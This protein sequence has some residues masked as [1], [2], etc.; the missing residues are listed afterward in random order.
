M[1]RL[2]LVRTSRDAEIGLEEFLEIEEISLT[3]ELPGFVEG[4][5]TYES[6]TFWVHF[7]RY[8]R[9]RPVE[10]REQKDSSVYIR[11][12]HG[13]GWELFRGD[14][15]LAKA[16]RGIADDRTMFFM[17]W[18]L[19]DIRREAHATG[20][21]AAASVFRKAFVAG[22][23]RKR[24]LPKQGKV[25]VWIEA[26]PTVE[27]DI[28]DGG[29][30]IDSLCERLNREPA[31]LPLRIGDIVTYRPQDESHAERDGEIGEIIADNIA[32]DG[33]REIRLRFSDG[34]TWTA[35]PE[36]CKPV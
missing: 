13:G 3:R 4:G 32:K 26:E 1:Q 24:A 19:A 27:R 7:A 2:A 5:T 9:E 28:G 33:V 20:Y 15:L 16:L 23:L 21:E 35:M 22:R 31:P 6:H 25:K 34:E 14:Y 30:E 10:G 11:V 12:R 29:E 8:K 18:T 17:C 36:E